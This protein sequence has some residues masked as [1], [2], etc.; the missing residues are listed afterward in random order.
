MPA[1]RVEAPY[2]SLVFRRDG[3]DFV[4][5][6]RVQVTAWRDG[7]QAG[8]GVADGRA[9]VTSYAATRSPERLLVEVPLVVRGTRNVQLEV[10]SL[11]P[12]TSRSWRQHLELSPRAVM[13]M[14]VVILGVDVRPAAGADGVHVVTAGDDTVTVDV[15][16]RAAGGM[17]WPAGG[18]CLKTTLRGAGR[19]RPQQLSLRLDP[20]RVA[21]DTTVHQSWPA[22]SLPFGRTELDLMLEAVQADQVERLPFGPRHE[23]LVLYVPVADD[24][25][26]RQHVGWLDGLLTAAEIDSLRR[27]PGAERPAAWAA[28]WARIAAQTSEEPQVGGNGAPA[29]RRR[30]RRAIRAVRPRRAQR[31]RA[32]LH[33]LRRTGEHRTD[34]RRPVA[35]GRLG[36][37]ALPL[38]RPAP[39]LLRRQRHRRF[40][41]GRGPPGLTGGPPAQGDARFSRKTS[42]AVDCPVVPRS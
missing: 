36:G 18:V 35:D 34:S 23:L 39:G 30:S 19:E 17:A 13:M 42:D 20:L 4:A 26:W 12:R 40:P 1:V 27:R 32:G 29:S 41:P 6:L 38:A 3:G 14:P 9:R 10:E 7:Q 11:V 25:V 16:L 37:L 22:R 28:A 8:G 2:S 15:R 31:S 24:H 21:A 33:P 5:D